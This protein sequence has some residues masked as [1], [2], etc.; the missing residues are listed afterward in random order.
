MYFSSKR[1]RQFGFFYSLTVKFSTFWR[2]DVCLEFL[3]EEGAFFNPLSD[4]KLIVM[5]RTLDLT[6]RILT[7]LEGAIGIFCLIKRLSF[8]PF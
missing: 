7:L 8:F 3:L 4:P 2:V 6:Q 1:T 5:L